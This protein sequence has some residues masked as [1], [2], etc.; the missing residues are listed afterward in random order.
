MPLV[1]TYSMLK[2]G[3]TLYKVLFTFTRNLKDEIEQVYY[4]IAKSHLKSAEQAFE[5]VLNSRSPNHELRSGLGHLRDAHNILLAYKEKKYVE[6]WLIFSDEKR[7]K[8]SD[9]AWLKAIET[10]A[11]IALIYYSFDE[12][13]NASRWKKKSLEEFEKYK[14]AYLSSLAYSLKEGIS[15]EGPYKLLSWET[16]KEDQYRD[17]RFDDLREVNRDYGEL[18]YPMQYRSTTVYKKTTEI[19]WKYAIRKVTGEKQML[20]ETLEVIR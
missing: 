12:T 16:V 20:E 1:E 10:S 6:G 13:V 9:S 3:V 2:G 15:R 17:D 11:L 18:E 7:V 5:A 4:D 8:F 14:N 19:G